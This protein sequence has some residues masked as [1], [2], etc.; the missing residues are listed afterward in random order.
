MRAVGSGP[1]LIIV[2][3]RVAWLVLLAAILTAGILRQFH[4]RI[5]T[6][7]FLPPPFGSLLFFLI[8]ILGLLFARGWGRRQEIPYAGPGLKQVNFLA[9]VPLMIAL[10]LEKWVSITLYGPLFAKLNGDRLPVS[11]F[12]NLYVLESALGLLVVCLFLLPMFQRLFPLLRAWFS[13]ARL[14]AAALGLALSVAGLYGALALLFGLV[15]GDGAHL[16]WTGYGRAAA[17]VLAGQAL[18]A[19]AEE[20]YYRGILQSELAFLL[21]ALGIV[22][23]KA[24]VL[25][26]ICLIS[27]A[28][29]LEHFLASGAAGI[30]A[31]RALFVFACS[32]LLGLLLF[33]T[34]NLW[35]CAGCHFV[36][37][38]FTMSGD[39]RPMG[40]QFLDDAGRPLL[41]P[42]I[43][44][45]L[46][47][48]MA[49]FSVYLAELFEKRIR[50]LMAQPARREPSGGAPPDGGAPA[51]RVG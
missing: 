5:P 41:S 8:V 50:P 51:T 40:L 20:F 38:L 28:F 47:F 48:I 33:L 3:R 9:F 36:L 18:I 13:P 39:P 30:D 23:E 43:Y 1:S 6:S 31:R 24:R 10:M 26:A 22:R 35:F 29:M 7:P 49:F 17:L 42:Q 32:L 21:P 27:L 37:N 2:S 14:P 44:I 15:G 19:L 12:N 11:L 46:F 34:K 16:R 25:T 4:A 45:F